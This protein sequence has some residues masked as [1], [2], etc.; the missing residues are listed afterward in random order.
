M[1]RLDRPLQEI[2]K[3]FRK[4]AWELEKQARP[5]S[6][7]QATQVAFEADKRLC[8]ILGLHDK[9]RRDWIDLSDDQRIDW[10]RHG[11]TKPLSRMTLYK[12][13]KKAMAPLTKND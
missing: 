6:R 5:M 11:P 9:A 2:V 12:A 4:N 10:E 1:I 7:F 13:I 3:P 8:L